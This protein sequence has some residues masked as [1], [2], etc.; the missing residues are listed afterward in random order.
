MDTA[1]HMQSGVDFVKALKLA[2]NP[3]KKEK[4]D[5]PDTLIQPPKVATELE[6]RLHQGATDKG[7]KTV[8]R[9]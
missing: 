2:K 8:V 6:N 1:R 7:I 5:E 3:P 4:K 9:L